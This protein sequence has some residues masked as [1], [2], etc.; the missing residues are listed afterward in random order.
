[1]SS[2][3]LLPLDF[4]LLEV[5]EHLYGLSYV[6]LQVL[7]WL[8]PL[9]RTAQRQTPGE[10]AGNPLTFLLPESEEVEGRDQ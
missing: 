4:L 5:T 7:K 2:M 9:G 6:Q 1:M 10:E 8:L 3:A